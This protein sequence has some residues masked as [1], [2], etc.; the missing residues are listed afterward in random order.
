MTGKPTARTVPDW[1]PPQPPVKAGQGCA[2]TGPEVLFPSGHYVISST[3]TPSTF[4]R[5]EG[6]E[7][8]YMPFP[9]CC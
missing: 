6:G 8:F 7:H 5:G 3:L 1:P 2:I 4:M 9:V